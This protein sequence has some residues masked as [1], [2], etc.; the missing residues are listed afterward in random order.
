MKKSVKIILGFFVLMFFLGALGGDNSENNTPVDVSSTIQ[1]TEVPIAET[2]KSTPTSTQ[3]AE[4]VYEDSEWASTVIQNVNIINIDLT[5]VGNAANNYDLSLLRIYAQQLVD[6]TQK[7]L[8]ED[9]AFKISP[10]YQDAREAYL[11]GLR[12]FNYAGQYSIR[13]VDELN[14]DNTEE[15]TE[16]LKKSTTFLESGGYYISQASELMNSA[17]G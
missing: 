14:N 5:G 3:T 15:G 6:D 9:E 10:I 17:I 16:Y 1:E 13:G 2:S 4:V 7:A 11:T 8:D 12:H